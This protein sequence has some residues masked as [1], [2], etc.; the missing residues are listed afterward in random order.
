MPND[1]P[2]RSSTLTGLYLD[3]QN[4]RLPASGTPRTQRQIIADLF[5]HED[6]L[7]LAKDIAANGYLQGELV[8]VAKDDNRRV[9]LEGNRRV[10]ALKVLTN[11]ESAPA[12]IKSRIQQIRDASPIPIPARVRTIEAPSRKAAE[13]FLIQRH[14][15]I[16]IQRWSMANQAQFVANLRGKGESIA[17]LCKRFGFDRGDIQRL[18]TTNDIYLVLLQSD[19]DEQLRSFVESAKFPLSTLMRVVESSSGR[20]WLGARAG[21]DGSLQITVP[22]EDFEEALLQI[23]K[24]LQPAGPRKKPVIDSRR[25]NNEEGIQK[26]LDSIGS[27][28]PSSRKGPP[29]NARRLLA[30]KAKTR[31][32]STKARKHPR[33]SKSL[34]PRDIACGYESGRVLD[35]F[36]EL[37]DL[38]LQTKPN[39]SVILFRT[40]LD[41]AITQYIEDGG[42]S[43][44]CMKYLQRKSPKRQ[45]RKNYHPTLRESLTFLLN[46]IE[47]PMSGAAVEAAKKV[48][49]RNST[50]SLDDLN[51]VVHNAYVPPSEEDARRIVTNLMPLLKLVLSP[52]AAEAE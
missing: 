8:M 27:K 31:S 41:L 29:A 32:T 21:E 11:P 34:L 9:V 23:A 38:P 45:F 37:K 5:E 24:D 3:P 36:L 20:R 35:V 15:G 1:W 10:A 44:D 39:A 7:S 52:I 26:Y 2:I 42:L 13:R 40:L 33:S 14:T 30:K 48:L 50:L 19:A 22:F 25:L 28:K 43:R 4:P 17:D 51:E 12:K 46:E 6:I 47:L 49:A 16:P 18:I